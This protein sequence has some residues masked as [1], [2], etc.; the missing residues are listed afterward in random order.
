M[1]I[2]SFVLG[3]LVVVLILG[4]VAGVFSAHKVFKLQEE[5]SSIM[6]SIHIENDNIYRKIQENSEL[7]NRRIDGEIDRTDHLIQD[8]YR[9][10]NS[11]FDK[12]ENKLTTK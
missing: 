6:N 11:R 12:L 1:E 3:M 5:L 8:V 4:I 7:D 2:T 9:T 10:M